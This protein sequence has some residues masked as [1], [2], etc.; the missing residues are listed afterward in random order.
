MI[1]SYDNSPIMERAPWIKDIFQ[2]RGINNG[3]NDDPAF[4][5]LINII[6]L[7]N[8]HNGTMMFRTQLGDGKDNRPWDLYHGGDT[9]LEMV[10]YQP[11]FKLID[12]FPYF[13]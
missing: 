3:F 2:H 1:V 8:H 6:L 4:K 10:L 11:L 12:F 7:L 5:V 13:V 9:T